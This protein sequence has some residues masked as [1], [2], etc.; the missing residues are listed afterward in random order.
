[1]EQRNRSGERTARQLLWLTTAVILG[2]CVCAGWGLR[3]VWGQSSA[4]APVAPVTGTPAA[5]IAVERRI[6]IDGTQRDFEN[7]I[8][9]QSKRCP[10]S[11]YI[12]V[13]ATPGTPVRLVPATATAA[14]GGTPTPT[15][16]PCARWCL[17]CPLSTVQG[18]VTVGY[19]GV[20][21]PQTTPAACAG[22]TCGISLSGECKRI[23][24]KAS[25]NDPSDLYVN[26]NYSLDGVSCTCD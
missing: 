23:P 7:A 16:F 14:P 21:A 15:P 11:V 22:L 25:T 6:D 17:C 24:I 19:T 3:A 2:L 12:A 9:A 20:A 26:G 5:D 8:H 10:I 18:D 4:S 1:M 13:V